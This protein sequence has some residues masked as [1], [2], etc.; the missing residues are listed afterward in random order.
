MI[1]HK[2][3]C[4]YDRRPVQFFHFEEWFIFIWFH[5]LFW[6]RAK[7]AT[8]FSHTSWGLC[9]CKN[10][11]VAQSLVWWFIGAIDNSQFSFPTTNFMFWIEI[12]IENICT[13]SSDQF[14]WRDSR[15]TGYDAN[16]FLFIVTNVFPANKWM[17]LPRYLD[18]S[19]K[20]THLIFT[21]TSYM[22]QWIKQYFSVA[23]KKYYYVVRTLDGIAVSY[24]C[25]QG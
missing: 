13:A 15:K 25:Q 24:K 6:T 21:N 10:D 14:F 20:F 3:G 4:F 16:S 23:Q 5:W 9:F 18:M 11:V 17:E 7:T 2:K 1:D 22:G 12:W 19:L 8:W